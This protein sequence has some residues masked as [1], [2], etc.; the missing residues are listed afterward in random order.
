MSNDDAFLEKL[1]ATFKIEAEEHLDA[2][3]KGLIDLEKDL[4][5]DQQVVLIEMIYR[6][7][8]N[9]KGAA[10]SVNEQTIQEVCQALE[11]VLSACKER[12]LKPSRVFFDI[13]YPTLDFIRLALKQPLERS[14]IDDVIRQLN[15]LLI[16]GKEKKAVAAVETPPKVLQPVVADHV[17]PKETTIRISLDKVDQLL[18]ETE[19]M[20]MVKLLVQDVTR[21]KHLQSELEGTEK[22]FKK[23]ASEFRSYLTNH[24]DEAGNKLL[25]SLDEHQQRIKISSDLV[26][27][28]TRS[29]EQNAHVVGNLVDKLL[30]DIK[31]VV[32]QP[33][34][35]LFEVLPRMVR[36]I[37]KS[38]GKEVQLEISG[39][40]IE[41]DRRILEEIKD[42]LIHII[43]NAIDHG[44]ETPEDRLKKNKPAKGTIRIVAS[45]TGGSNVELQISDDGKGF[46]LEKIKETATKKAIVSANDL[47][48][49]S[50]DEIVKLAFHSGLS[51]SPIITELSGRGLGLG[52]V[53]EK[54][55]KLG[56]RVV[57][58][59][60]PNQG[61]TFRIILPV[62][63][64]TFRGVHVTVG[65]LDYIIPANN[66]KRV[67]RIKKA[68]I[69]TVENYETINIEGHAFSFVHL[70]SLLKVGEESSHSDDA[71]FALIVKAEERV[72]AFG[73]DQIHHEQEVLV[74][75][76]GKQCQRVKNVM[77]ASI[78]EGGKVIP[79]LNPIDLIRSAIQGGVARTQ[80]DTQ[81]VVE[82]KKKTILIAEDSI[83]TRLLLKNILE[84]AGYATKTAIDGLEAYEM[85][86]TQ[87]VDLLLTDV[88]MPR[89]D[90]FTLVAKV[91]GKASL[92]ALPI[93]MC[94]ARGS[95]E[96]RER[97]IEL[98]AN[99][100]VDKSSFSQSGILNIIQSL[101]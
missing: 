20:L 74:K 1:L 61:T 68:D 17:D 88:E 11:N 19:E 28:L 73:V 24:E 62:T 10:R 64:A 7:A 96:D 8:H 27:K 16:P 37:S 25:S 33:L 3:S 92:A 26:H 100:Y 77:A 2:L 4:P 82:V 14:K 78:M 39:E 80:F 15:V 48:G 71:L 53:S 6:E 30:E 43:R 36:D 38:L 41:V 85:L 81:A 95:N 59:S 70:S 69:K 23:L 84:T 34:S 22:E 47:K 32:M 35:T 86:Q 94:T 52:I 44:I 57:V 55:D 18:H 56:G 29:S 79:I 87:K 12:Q 66:V 60:Q 67:L 42:P 63:L 31:K 93:V 65:E 45:E 40:T 49:M 9:L 72:I 54:A 91:K 46:D 97:G 98:G 89:M 50:S 76:L 90:G 21:L 51:T 83:T 13:L 75:S 99:A 58:E 101:L 5:E